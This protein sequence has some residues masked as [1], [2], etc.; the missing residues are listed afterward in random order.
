MAATKQHAEETVPNWCLCCGFFLLYVRYAVGCFF[1]SFYYILG[2][3]G[4]AF[5]CERA[6]YSV[7]CQFDQFTFIPFLYFGRSLELIVSY[8]DRTK[9]PIN[10]LQNVFAPR[11]KKPNFPILIFSLL[12]QMFYCVSHVTLYLCKVLKFC[13]RFHKLSSYIRDIVWQR[14]YSR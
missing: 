11:L 13:V 2:A 12:A 3:F 8:L 14:K 9:F 4:S 6:A 10:S 7:Y 5:I 1:L